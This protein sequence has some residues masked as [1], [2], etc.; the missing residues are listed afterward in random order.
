MKLKNKKTHQEIMDEQWPKIYDFPFQNHKNKH[1]H[2]FRFMIFPFKIKIK[3]TNTKIS[4][5]WFSLSKSQTQTQTQT[6]HM[7]ETKWTQKKK[8]K[9][10][11][12]EKD[13]ERG[14]PVETHGGSEVAG[15][16]Q[17]GV[18]TN[19]AVVGNGDAGMRVRVTKGKS[20]WGWRRGAAG[21]RLKLEWVRIR[22]VRVRVRL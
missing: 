17:W 7:I 22:E 21:M 20:V 14:G 5:L 6:T 12:K 1:K 3:N 19:G 18:G 2:K 11:E 9:E 15:L 4:D 16:R 10:K 8:R 13:R